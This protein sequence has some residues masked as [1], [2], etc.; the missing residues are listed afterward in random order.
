MKRDA[1]GSI[2]LASALGDGCAQLRVG[3]FLTNEYACSVKASHFPG[4]AAL[5]V[6]LV[7]LPRRHPN[8]CHHGAIRIFK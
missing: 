4:P 8:R 5:E 2:I 7:S 6:P 3:L 1:T